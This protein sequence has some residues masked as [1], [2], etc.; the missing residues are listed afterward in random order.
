MF[1]RGGSRG[2]IT[3]LDLRRAHFGL[4]RHLLGKVPWNKALE[5]GPKKTGG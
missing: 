4:F 5:V 1:S 3:T 2:K